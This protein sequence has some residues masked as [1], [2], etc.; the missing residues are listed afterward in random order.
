MHPMPGALRQS[1]PAGALLLLALLLPAFPASASTLLLAV[2]ETDDG[3]PSALPLAAR[4]GCLAALFDAGELGFD[5]PA[6]EP[7]PAIEALRGLAGGAGAD[8]VAEIVIEWHLEAINRGATRVSGRGSIVLTDVRTGQ[9]VAR[10]AVAV[11]NEDRERT[12]GRTAL[13]LE[14]G[15]RLVEELRRASG[16]G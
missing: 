4:E 16:R 12:A 11:T 14:I 10:I 3:Q 15:S 9:E 8:I 13:G 7:I 5:L 2:T 1:V 6:G